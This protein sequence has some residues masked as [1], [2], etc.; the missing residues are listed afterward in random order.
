MDRWPTTRNHFVAPSD[1]W[2]AASW[3]NGP[4]VKD[5]SSERLIQTPMTPEM[6]KTP[7]R[8]SRRVQSPQRD[9]AAAGEIDAVA[10]FVAF[11]GQTRGAR[12]LTANVQSKLVE[13]FTGPAAADLQE[14]PA[15]RKLDIDARSSALP[16]AGD[17][18]ANESTG[19]DAH[20]QEPDLDGKSS[21]RASVQFESDCT[22]Q[23][24]MTVADLPM[25]T[26]V[27]GWEQKWE[28]IAE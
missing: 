16:G 24:L 17:T 10:P 6:R 25:D 5:V 27:D 26:D 15:W 3:S 13:Y 9:T 11:F 7:S 21:R 4:F 18:L 20:R 12:A 8:G 23:T 19:G 28:I 14:R 2:A 22:T 1:T